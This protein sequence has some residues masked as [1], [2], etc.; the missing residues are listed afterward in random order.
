M[1][2]GYNNFKT[3]GISRPTKENFPKTLKL[4]RRGQNYRILKMQQYFGK[5]YGVQKSSTN[6]IQNG[7]PKQKSRC[8]MKN[9]LQRKIT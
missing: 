3:I 7:L 4:K 5:E 8:H 1:T 6:R 2:T 9:R